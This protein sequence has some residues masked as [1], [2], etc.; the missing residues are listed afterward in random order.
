MKVAAELGSGIWARFTQLLT[1]PTSLVNM[2]LLTSPQ[3]TAVTKEV[4]KEQLEKVRP[5]TK[6]VTPNKSVQLVGRMGRETDMGA[7]DQNSFWFDIA[8]YES[9]QKH[10]YLGIWSKKIIKH[11]EESFSTKIFIAYAE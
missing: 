3:D 8:E 2:R 9:N 6:G 7:E 1:G 4:T 10:P 11:V 5:L